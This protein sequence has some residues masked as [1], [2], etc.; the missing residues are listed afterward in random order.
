MRTVETTAPST[1]EAI[2][3]ELV[4][5]LPVGVLLQDEHGEVL[6]ANSLAADLLGLHRRE[7]LD[8][9]RPAGW[10]ACDDSGAPLPERAE[11]AGQV[12]RTGAPLTLPLV[13]TRDGVPHVRL[14]ADYHPIRLRG[15]PCVLVLLQPVH[16]D[17]PHSK[18]LLDP[19]TGLPG[20][21]LLLDRLDQAL[22]RAR[23]HGTLASLVL[24]DVHRLASVNAEHG[25]HRGDEL[26]T[27][28]AGRLRQGLR[29]D[30]T[31]ARYGG[32]EFAIV[33]E[34]PDGTGEPLAERVRELAG[35]AV[36]VGGARLR[37]GVR[38]CWVTSDGTAPTHSV[39]SVVDERLRR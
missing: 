27:V 3:R 34:H 23:T 22:T 11:L 17:V 5:E 8:G 24:V 31:V 29:A 30:H 7:L 15:R 35:R 20:R 26:L 25:F 2:W 18:G 14:W 6:A 13:V 36:R 16:T 21:A 28:L 39:V 10:L 9:S 1:A 33:A 32:D 4:A 12:L 38:V 19:L 37:P